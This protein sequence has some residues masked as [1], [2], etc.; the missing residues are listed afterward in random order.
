MVES[1]AWKGPSRHPLIAAASCFPPPHPQ[2]SLAHSRTQVAPE[3]RPGSPLSRGS[4]MS[5]CW[6]L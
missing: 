2:T 4:G 1:L 3:P 5:S 6:L